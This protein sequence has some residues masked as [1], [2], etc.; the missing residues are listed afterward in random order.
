MGFS[1]LAKEAIDASAA[2]EL[3]QADTSKVRGYLDMIET[4]SLPAPELSRG[5][6]N[7]AKA[8]PGTTANVNIVEIMDLA[9]SYI[10]I[11]TPATLI[12]AEPLM[13]IN[14]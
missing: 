12:D 11:L 2:P 4:A 10:P 8:E 6:W 14:S 13:R 9:E 3:S 7:F 5:I 1:E